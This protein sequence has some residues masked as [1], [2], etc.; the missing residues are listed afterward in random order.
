MLQLSRSGLGELLSGPIKKGKSSFFF[1][2]NHNMVDNNSIINAL[3]LDPSL[4]IVSF[5]QDV[6]VPTRRTGF[7]PRFDFAINDKNTIVN[8]VQLWP[9]DDQES[10]HWRRFAAVTCVRVKE[11]RARVA[12]H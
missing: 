2:A 10:G 3:V 8:A 9:R 7:S 11:Q 4:N 5:Q 1:D 6:G 12:A